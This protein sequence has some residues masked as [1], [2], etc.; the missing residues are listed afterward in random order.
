MTGKEEREGRE[1]R[2]RKRKRGERG[3]TRE[4]V[5]AG[6]IWWKRVQESGRER[7]IED[8][9]RGRKTNF[10]EAQ[11]NRLIHLIL[12]TELGVLKEAVLCSIQV[13]NC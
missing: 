3:R 9:G 2:R 8:V 13:V 7:C 5:E 4:R 1:E 6:R 10:V 12:P 11:R